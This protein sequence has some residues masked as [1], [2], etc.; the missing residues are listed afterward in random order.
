MHRTAGVS[1]CRL[2][3]AFGITR[4]VCAFRPG[5]S[6]RERKIQA[7]CLRRFVLGRQQT[8]RLSFVAGLEA[9]LFAGFDVLGV[10]PGFASEQPIQLLHSDVLCYEDTGASRLTVS[11]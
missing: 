5:T 9:L 3:V 4:R 8:Q 7:R 1:Q 2:C 10:E 11:K 6:A